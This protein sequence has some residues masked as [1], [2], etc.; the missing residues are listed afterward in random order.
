MTVSSGA[1]RIGKIDLDD[2]NW[3]QRRYDRWRAYGQSKLA[4]LLFTA[5]APAAAR[6]GRL[7]ACARSPRTPATRRRNLQSHTGSRSQ[8]AVMR[9]GNRLFAQSDEMGALPTLYAATQDVPGDSFV[10]PR[11]P[12]RAARPAEA[13]RPLA[14]PPRNAGD[15]RRPVGARPRS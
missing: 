14:A 1:H 10:G 6:R 7:A 13:R 8:D 3:E 2:L 12:L 9:V 4:N 5:R 15:A 11:R